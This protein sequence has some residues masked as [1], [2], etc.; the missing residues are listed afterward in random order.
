ML[1]KKIAIAILC[2]TMTTS[3]MGCG[4]IDNT[5]YTLNSAGNVLNSIGILGNT[6]TATTT[7]STP[8]STST[9]T[10][11]RSTSTNQSSTVYSSSS[12]STSSSTAAKAPSPTTH[13]IGRAHV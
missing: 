1:M 8:R 10:T 13:K 4:S 9:S 3:L 5:L 7:S 6:P 11:P 12:A 2:T